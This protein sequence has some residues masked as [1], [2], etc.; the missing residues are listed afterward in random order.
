VWAATAAIVLSSVACARSD[1]TAPLPFITVQPLVDSLYAGDSGA[2]FLATYY[3]GNGTPG[4]SG[5]QH[6]AS[7]DTT[8]V[9]VDSLTGTLKGVGAGTATVT[10]AASGVTGQ[11]L[12]VVTGTLDLALLLPQ[13]VLLPQDSFTVPFAVRN[14]AGGSPPVPFFKASSNGVFTIDSATGRAVS[15]STGGPLPFQAI[16]DTLVADGSVQVVTMTDTTGGGGAYTVNGSVS[17]ARTAT[18][19]ATDYARSGG[20]LTF[21]LTFKVVV[22]GVTTE[23]VNILSQNA[24]TA[25]DSLAIDSVSTAEAQSNTFLCSPPRSAA[26]WT[27]TSQGNPIL[28]VSRAGGYVKVRK[29]IPVTGGSAIAG[30]FF[31]VG[32]RA[33][34]YTDPSG[35]LAIRGEFVAPLITNTNTCH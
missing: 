17:A 12:V 31:F 29:I 30:S 5:P 28:A 22:N 19:R 26:A 10:V 32:Q 15:V 16:L 2:A 34:D 21:L 18:V 33:D 23:I 1:N 25:V 8:V 27:S 13:I 9:R 6:W 35:A 14:K 3:N 4:T 24:V 7:T 20:T 11:A